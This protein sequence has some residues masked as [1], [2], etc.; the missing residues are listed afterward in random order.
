MDVFFKALPA[1]PAESR[2]KGIYFALI[3][4]VLHI[5]LV[6]FH[7]VGDLHVTLNLFLSG[8]PHES[9]Q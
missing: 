9:T 6:L 1:A 3:V 2:G 4:L 7:W 5:V 8:G